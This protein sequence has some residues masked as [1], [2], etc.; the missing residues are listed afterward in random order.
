M[1]V[2]RNLPSDLPLID[3][4]WDVGKEENSFDTRMLLLVSGAY[5]YGYYLEGAQNQT[6]N[7]MSIPLERL[8]IFPPPITTL[9]FL[10]FES[11]DWL[12]IMNGQE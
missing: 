1:P 10:T 9:S 3:K 11:V 4:H 6:E 12:D 2:G 8:G 5:G 7:Q